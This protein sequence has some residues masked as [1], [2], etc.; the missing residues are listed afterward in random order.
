[1]ILLQAHLHTATSLRGVIFKVLPL[2]SY[3]IHPMMMPML[4]TFLE[5]LL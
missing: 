3:A 5:L 4:E 2:S 1:M